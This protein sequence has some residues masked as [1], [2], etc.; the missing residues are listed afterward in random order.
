MGQFL[1]MGLKNILFQEQINGCRFL[2]NCSW[3]LRIFWVASVDF[4]NPVAGFR[5]GTIS[6]TSKPRSRVLCFDRTN[7]TTLSFASEALS[8]CRFRPVGNRFYRTCQL[9]GPAQ[10]R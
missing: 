2:P 7:F 8:P 1:Y 4:A 10:Y 6:D 9:A 5:G 3:Q